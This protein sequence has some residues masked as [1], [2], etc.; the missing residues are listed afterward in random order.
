MSIKERRLDIEHR[1]HE[2]DT[3]RKRIEAEL[4]ALQHVCPHAR[5]KTWSD[6]GWGRMSS[7]Y[8]LCEDCGLRKVT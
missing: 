1:L 7:S 3:L 2:H 6:S 4:L 5:V 8:W